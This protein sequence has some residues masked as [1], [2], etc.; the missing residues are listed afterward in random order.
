MKSFQLHVRQAA[1]EEADEISAWYEAQSAGLG[2][3][4]LDALDNCFDDLKVNPFL[5]LRKEPFRFASIKGFPSFRVVF[6]VDGDV[7]TVYQVRHTSRKPHPTFG[8]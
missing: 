7:I 1:L 5:Q 3:R 4:F 8:P 6:V 2:D